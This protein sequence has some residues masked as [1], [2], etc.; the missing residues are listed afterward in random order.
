[1]TLHASD[2]GDVVP[3][4][5]TIHIIAGGIGA[6]MGLGA[7]AFRKGE[8]AHRAAGTVFVAAMVVMAATAAYIAWR[9]QSITLVDA[10]M[11]IY[12]VVTSWLTI[13]TPNARVGPAGFA[14]LSFVFLLA[15]LNVWLGWKALQA[16][17]GHLYGYPPAP[18]LIFGAVA[19]LAGAADLRVVFA[20]GIT[21]PAR[22]AR[23]LWRMCV[24]LFVGLASFATQG[25]RHVIPHELVGSPLHWALILGPALIPMVLMV[26]W[27]I[28][29]RTK[30]W[31][32]SHPDASPNVAPA[33]A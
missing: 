4:V 16:P 15:G 29:I 3:T 32:R 25:L 24:A 22:I 28:R 9:I 1:M 12:L 7:L 30:A 13:R 26:F 31:G 23:H 10:L 5:L 8:A 17:S 19:A 20:G 6:V 21:G 33:Q 27:L 11:T 2:L 18:Y 14:A